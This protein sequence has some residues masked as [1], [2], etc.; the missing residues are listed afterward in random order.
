VIPPRFSF[1]LT[2]TELA[3]LKTLGGGRWLR[4]AIRE[5]SAPAP[6]EEFPDVSIAQRDARII[7]DLRPAKLIAAEWKI[8]P[9]TVYCIRHH[10]RKAGKAVVEFEQSKGSAKHDRRSGNQIR[11]TGVLDAGAPPPRGH[12]LGVQ[13]SWPANPDLRGAGIPDKQRQVP[14]SQGSSHPSGAKESTRQGQRSFER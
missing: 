1:E 10:A 12:H 11:G 5:A 2:K 14:G 8:S 6:L 3:K 4:K 13:H 7:A 9:K